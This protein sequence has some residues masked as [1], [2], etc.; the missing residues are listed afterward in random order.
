[1]LEM[2]EGAIKLGTRPPFRG[3]STTRAKYSNFRQFGTGARVKVPE[4]GA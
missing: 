1:M 2:Y 3:S 4:K